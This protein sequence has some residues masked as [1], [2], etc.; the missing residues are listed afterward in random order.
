MRTF[1]SILLAFS[2]MVIAAIADV[3][4]A[5]VTF[6]NATNLKNAAWTNGATITVKI[7]RAHV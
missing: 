1:S 5:R 3:V 7:G 6:T 2:L 4:T